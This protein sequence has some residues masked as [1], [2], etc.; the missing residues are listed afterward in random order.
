MS[1]TASYLA[2]KS[3]TTRVRATSRRCYKRKAKH[4]R[5]VNITAVPDSDNKHHH[6]IFLNTIDRP[7]TAGP[8]AI[9]ILR[10]REL[11]VTS[12]TRIS[13]QIHDPGV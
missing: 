12:G 4:S 8:N 6:A 5:P 10:A 1:H 3:L 11:D 9:K 2:L 7:I 13:S